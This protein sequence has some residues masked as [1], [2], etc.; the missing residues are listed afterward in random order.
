MQFLDIRVRDIG[1]P[2]LAQLWDDIPVQH[3]SVI[4]CASR[5]LLRYRMIKQVP[6]RKFANGVRFAG[7]TVF[8]DG[9]TAAQN[10]GKKA[11]GDLPCCM[12]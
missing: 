3:R 7:G 2:Q 1:N 9:I 11:F 10:I 8:C 12:K 4:S 5:P 6:F